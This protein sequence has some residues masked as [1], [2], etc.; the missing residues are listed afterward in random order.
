MKQG[1][2][3]KPAIDQLER[4]RDLPPPKLVLFDLDDTLADY[5]TARRSRLRR[6]FAPYLNS[7]SGRETSGLLSEM[8]AASIKLSPHG[9][10]HFPELFATFGIRDASAAAAAAGWFRRHRFH[11]L[12]LFPEAIEI[13]SAVRGA[14]IGQSGERRVGIVTN[15]PAGVQRDKLELLG[16]ER[17]VDFAIISGEVGCEKPDPEIFAIALTAAGEA[18]VDAIFV[19]DSPYFD[20]TG[21]RGAG[22]R[23]VWVNRQREPWPYAD[24]QP[25]FVVN[26][27]A[28][29]VPLLIGS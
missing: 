29:L 14:P 28:E 23:S 7:Q 21:A 3:V 11:D 4:A 16:V 22:I 12:A 6:A 15:G 2:P 26:G 10:D 24:W 13:L 1:T 5:S 8:I 18:P 19:G 17:Y 27:L 9:V 20:I 25:T